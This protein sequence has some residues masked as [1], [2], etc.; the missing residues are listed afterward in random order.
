M[1]RLGVGA[2]KVRSNQTTLKKMRKLATL[3]GRK[4]EVGK[5]WAARE[6]RLLGA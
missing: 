5:K 2:M 3:R 1:F 4:A 6:G